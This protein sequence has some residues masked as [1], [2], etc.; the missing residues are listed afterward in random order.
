MIK[1]LAIG[2][3]E[4]QTAGVTE[5]GRVSLDPAATESALWSLLPAT[6]MFVSVLL[7]PAKARKVLLFM[8]LAIGVGNVAMGAAQLA[9]GNGSPLRLYSPTNL[10]QAVGF[11]ANRNHMLYVTPVRDPRSNEVTHFV[12]V[13]HDITEL[14][15]Y[16][17]ELEHQANHDALTGLANRNLL[18]DRLHQQLALAHRYKRSF[19]VAFIDLDNFKLINDSLGHDVGDRLLRIAGERLVSCV[20]DGDTV[21]RPGGDEFVLLVAERNNEGGAYRVVQR[22]M[23]SS[24]MTM[25]VV[26]VGHV[27]MRV[28]HR[29]VPM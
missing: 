27:G 26:C 7:V 12:G 25:Q 2:K 29:L 6:A 16:Q 3:D 17:D 11:F 4:L 13:Q 19:S 20:R 10:D 1:N 8:L 9:G 18:K 5:H 28:T 15:R 24:S 21:A 23:P 14:K 22:V